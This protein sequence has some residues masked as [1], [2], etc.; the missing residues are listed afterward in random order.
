MTP[1]TTVYM[2]AGYAVILAGVI[3]YAISLLWRNR[4]D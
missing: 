2:I 1:D 4:K 3:F